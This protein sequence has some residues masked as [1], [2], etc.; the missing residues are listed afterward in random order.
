ME[1]QII[2]EWKLEGPMGRKFHC[3]VIHQR[4]SMNMI[5]MYSAPYTPALG[6]Y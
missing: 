3:F 6:S 4:T 1:G 5:D 2:Q